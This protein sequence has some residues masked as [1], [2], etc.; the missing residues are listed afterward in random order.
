MVYRDMQEHYGRKDAGSEAR[1]K[2]VFNELQIDALYKEYEQST[3]EKL[4]KLIDSI[5]EAADPAQ[6]YTKP[7]SVSF[8]LL[9]AYTRQFIAYLFP[10]KAQAT[11]YEPM[12]EPY[13]RT[14]SALGT[15]IDKV[16]LK[17]EVFRSFLNKI[18]K[19]QK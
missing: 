5:P 15:G 14:I 4:N 16:T 13:P 9:V 11:T 12:L 17:R 10:A 1:V 19:R 6:Q 7:G 18:Y 8:S 3:Y 2:E